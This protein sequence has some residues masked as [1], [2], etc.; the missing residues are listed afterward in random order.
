MDRREALVRLMADGALHSGPQLARALS[1]SRAAVWKSLQALPDWG[2]QVESVAA[3]GYQLSC[4][5][6]LLDPD[7]IVAGLP[8]QAAAQ[9][10]DLQVA[11]TADSTNLR[12]VETA[13]PAPGKALAMLAEFQTGGRGRRGRRWQSPLGSG[14]CLSLSWQFS[15]PPPG[16]SALGPA[17]GVMLRR[18]LA[19]YSADAR[20]K[21]P[22]DIVTAG[23]KL[24]GLLIDVQG[25][26][27]GPVHV[28]IGVGVNVSRT[29]VL[30]AEETSALPPVCLADG[31][32]LPARNV[33]AAGLI[34]ALL[35][36]LP[37][38]AVEGFA[39]F[40]DEWQRWDAFQGQTVWVS[41]GET[42]HAGIARGI[43]PEGALLLEIDGQLEQLYSGDVS[44]RAAA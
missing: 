30:P 16:L 39:S 33:L 4:P 13:P 1:C 3:R 12:L 34:D 17:V 28:V 19:D 15:Y 9:L 29:P 42:R 2:L 26:S 23:G 41:V 40:A 35:S 36:G 18:E 43:S 11:W 10:N 14:V 44:L 6:D 24:A 32:Q 22:N 20:L 31:G 25:E 37:K 27:D 5:L 7:T 8:A 38:F 21:W